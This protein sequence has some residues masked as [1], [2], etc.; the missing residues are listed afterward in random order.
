MERPLKYQLICWTCVNLIK[1][2]VTFKLPTEDWCSP[3][4]YQWVHLILLALKPEFKIRAVY[5]TCCI[6]CA[7]M[8]SL[9]FL[10]SFLCVPFQLSGQKEKEKKKDE[11]FSTR[12]C[13]YKIFFFDVLVTK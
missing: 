13:V 9:C 12:K 8:I 5:A 2:R 7:A 1:Y 6:Y 4:K 3:H 11:N 10:M